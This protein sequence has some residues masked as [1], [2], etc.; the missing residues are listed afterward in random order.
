MLSS[1]HSA[2]QMLYDKGDVLL[3]V[4]LGFGNFFA[5]GVPVTASVEF[6][7][8]DAIS[9]GPYLGFTSYRYNYVGDRWS[10]TFIDF[11]GRG[12]YHFGKHINMNTDKLDLYGAALLGY[13]V[14]SYS[15]DDTIYGNPYP[16][17]VRFGVVGGARWYF[18]DM[19]SVNGEVGYGLAPLMLGISFK[20]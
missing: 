1:R 6:A 16:S 2:A 10:S 12:S 7:I 8:T 3:N 19:F 13:T 20:L 11:G 15:G 4:G 9:I 14:S 5:G 17:A 18:T